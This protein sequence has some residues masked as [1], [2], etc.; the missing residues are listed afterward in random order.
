MLHARKLVSCVYVLRKTWKKG[1]SRCRRARMA[2]KCTKKRDAR[3]K[4]LF[5]QSKPINFLPS[6]LLKLPNLSNG[7]DGKRANKVPIST[8]KY[9]YSSLKGMWVD[10][11]CQRS[12]VE[13]QRY[14]TNLKRN[15]ATHRPLNLP[16]GNVSRLPLPE[17]TGWN[18]NTHYKLNLEIL[19]T[20]L[21]VGVDSGVAAG[22]R[23]G[24]VASLFK[25]WAVS[26][27]P[28]QKQQ[29]AKL[30]GRKK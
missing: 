3:A 4:L 25:T 12:P 8:K 20:F 16:E 15:I 17:I 18:T 5:C 23:S 6:S 1:V 27:R 21:F 9:C 13:I 30:D 14:I 10:C 24:K 19:N 7:K 26:W 29:T 2:K 28:G 22:L 11:L